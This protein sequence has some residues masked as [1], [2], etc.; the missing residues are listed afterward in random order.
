MKL[1]ISLA[2]STNSHSYWDSMPTTFCTASGVFNAMMFFF[3]S[4]GDAAGRAPVMFPKACTANAA[5]YAGSSAAGSSAPSRVATVPCSP[6]R[7]EVEAL[8][9]F[10][11]PQT[12]K[13]LKAAALVQGLK[14]HSLLDCITLF[15]GCGLQNL[16]ATLG[17]RELTG[18]PFFGSCAVVTQCATHQGHQRFDGR[19]TC[20]APGSA[21]C[22]RRQRYA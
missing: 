19:Q 7:Q 3:A 8:G 16:E 20:H 13:P 11:R 12:T 21:C 15:L 17:A 5:S 2:F 6:W 4:S 1:R 14:G 9:L 18:R 22:M 10:P